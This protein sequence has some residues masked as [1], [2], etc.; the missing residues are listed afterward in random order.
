MNSTNFPSAVGNNSNGRLIAVL[1]PVRQLL[2]DIEDVAG[3]A[4]QRG[5]PDRLIEA[6]LETRLRLDRE[7]EHQ[8]IAA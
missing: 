3:A 7:I 6:V 8:R 5:L 2:H 1:E 4:G